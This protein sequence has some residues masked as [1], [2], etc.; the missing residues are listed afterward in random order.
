MGIMAYEETCDL[1]INAPTE[2]EL[3]MLFGLMDST[4]LLV[5]FMQ[6][7]LGEASCC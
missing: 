6:G 2:M 3:Y 4:F 7:S 5:L 1:I